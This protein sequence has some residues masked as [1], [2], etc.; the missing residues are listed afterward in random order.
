MLANWITLARLPLLL[1]S[2]GALYLGTPPVQLVGAALLLLGFLLDTLDGLVARHTGQTSLF[3][4]VLDIAADRL[5]ELALWVAL[6]D[7]RLVP[8]TLPLI[9]IAR[10][11]L[12]DALRS[13]G[14][15][16]GRAPL[17]QHESTIG[18]FLV[19]SPWMRI[20]YS[21]SKITTFC[22]L[23]LTHA[24]REWPDTAA[25]QLAEQALPLLQISAWITVVWCVVRGLPVLV[26][27]LHRH[28]GRSNS[29]LIRVNH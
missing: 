16:Q 20:G 11:V 17:T 15:G 1:L 4:S 18:R 8:T 2:L 23:A 19:G 3:G 5:Y 7:L 25:Q 29:P 21:I 26:G 28:W 6:A 12:T 13:L 10:T 9:V 14:V 27:S 24:F 22:G